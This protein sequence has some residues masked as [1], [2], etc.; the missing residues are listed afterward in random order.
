MDGNSCLDGS[1]P[2]AGVSFDAIGNLYGTTEKGGAKFGSGTIYKLSPSSDGWTESALIAFR[3]PYNQGAGPLSGV[4]FDA[5]GNLYGTTAL[6]GTADQGTVFKLSSGG[7]LGTFRFNGNGSNGAN[8]HA[9]VLPGTGV[10]YGT[11][12]AGGTDSGGNVFKIQL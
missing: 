6:G 9:N 4:S 12:T 7:R 5:S 1:Q 10:V 3:A 8:P 2:Q 11:A